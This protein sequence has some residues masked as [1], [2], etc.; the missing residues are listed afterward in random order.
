MGCPKVPASLTP[1]ATIY[2]L[3]EIHITLYYMVGFC[4]ILL[5][6]LARTSLGSRDVGTVL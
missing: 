3:S 4:N 2:V 6:F 5:T 1:T